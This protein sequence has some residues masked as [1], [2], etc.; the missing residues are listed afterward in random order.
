[1]PTWSSGALVYGGAGG[2]WS[3]LAA[4][5][6]GYV[7]VMGAS[8]PAWA[9]TTSIATSTNT[10]MGNPT[11]LTN[12]TYWGTRPVTMTAGTGISA[13]QVCYIGSDSKMELADAT[14]NA[15][16]KENYWMA[17]ANVTED[18]TGVFIGSGSYICNTS[19][20]FTAGDNLW[21]SAT[22]GAVTST[23]VTAS[24]N[25]SQGLGQ[26]IE[27]DTIYFSVDPTWI[28]ND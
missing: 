3:N 20:S 19:W 9:A 11:S 1:M 24:D 14:S 13:F 17:V 12:G 15:T 8:Y 25:I 28:Q 16:V 21:L 18:Q 26:A 6:Q 10:T 23:Q 2:K 5:T 7:L 27:S 22:A 4:G